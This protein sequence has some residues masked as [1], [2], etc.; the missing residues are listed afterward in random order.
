VKEIIAVYPGSFDPVTHGHLDIIGRGARIFGRVVVAILKNPQKKPTFSL[1]ERTRLLSRVVRDL[2]NVEVDSF[3]GLLV[4]YARS[5]GARVIV[6]GLRAVSDFEYEF[7]MALMNRRLDSSIETIFM[8]PR[9]DYA[10]VSSGLVKEVA[11]LGG[12]IAD[13]VP[14]EVARQLRPRRRKARSRR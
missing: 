3:S 14:A 4:D 10:Y 6:R 11:S 13:L 5:R 9:E 1:A 7:Q 8:A 12:D 2:G